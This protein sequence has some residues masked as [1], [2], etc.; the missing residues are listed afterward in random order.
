MGTA[1]SCW[2]VNY[3]G[4]FHRSALRRALRTVDPFIVRWAQRKYKR[5]RGHT[6][7]A[8]G[9]LRGAKSHQPNLF[10][11]WPMESLVGAIGAG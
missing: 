5:F 4:R 3:F 11:H 7:R 8:W 2:L 1:Y 10:A 9:W 6:K